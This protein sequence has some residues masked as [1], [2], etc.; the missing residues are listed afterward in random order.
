VAS[1]DLKLSTENWER[2][3]RRIRDRA[4]QLVSRA[5][6]RANVSGRTVMVRA[7]TEHL[8]IKRATVDKAVKK[9]EAVPHRL[10]ARV[11]VRGGPISLMHFNAKGPYPSRGRGNGVT[12]RLPHGQVRYPHG[13]LAPGKNRRLQAFERVGKARMPIVRLTG[14]SMPDIFEVH[15]AKGIAA[16]E[17]SLVKNLQHEFAF[18]LSQGS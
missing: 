5:L 18:A 16:G 8:R 3:I 13:F 12:A 9:S 14:P 2:S 4:P 11:W 15:R 10:S 7:M 17:E 6:N 1:L